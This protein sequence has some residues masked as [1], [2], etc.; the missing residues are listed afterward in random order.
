MMSEQYSWPSPLHLRHATHANVR[1]VLVD[2]LRGRCSVANSLSNM[3]EL[4]AHRGHTSVR[5][6][7]CSCSSSHDLVVLA[8]RM[9]GGA[10]TA[11][12][13]LFVPGTQPSPAS[14]TAYLLLILVSAGLTGL[15]AAERYYESL[16]LAF[17]EIDGSVG[18]TR[19]SP[20]FGKPLGVLPGFSAPLSFGNLWPSIVL[21]MHVR[22][23]PTQS[24]A[25]TQLLPKPHVLGSP[26]RE[27]E[28]DFSARQP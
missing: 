20:A 10:R 7:F 27:A 24:H 11:N 28:L 23:W 21:A 12:T 2:T 14:V 25:V 6:A 19:T 3:L 4:V 5:A 8:A 18:K 13:H 22:P 9:C 16:S 1:R 17:A 26:L 15:I